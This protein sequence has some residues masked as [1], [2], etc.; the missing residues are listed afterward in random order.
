[1][2]YSFVFGVP[3]FYPLVNEVDALDDSKASMRIVSKLIR[4]EIRNLHRWEVGREP[5]ESLR[6]R[7]KNICY[8]GPGRQSI[9]GRRDWLGCQGCSSSGLPRSSTPA[10]ENS[11]HA[12]SGF[13][14]PFS[15]GVPLYISLKLFNPNRLQHR[16][17]LKVQISSQVCRIFLA[18]PPTICT[19]LIIAVHKQACRP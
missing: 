10:P 13:L 15:L 8:S 3:A 17:L 16:Q 4:V 2:H 12:S 5:S 7:Y 9:V 6:P 11:M 19:R 18:G 14:L 1:M